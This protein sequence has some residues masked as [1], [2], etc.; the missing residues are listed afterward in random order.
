[1]ITQKE[2]IEEEQAILDQVIDQL[3]KAMMKENKALTKSMLEHQKAKD[4]CLPETYGDLVKSL[5][6]EEAAK[7]NLRKALNIKNELYDSHIRLECR[8]GIPST[9]GARPEIVDLKV[10]LH[11]YYQG[12]DIIVISWVRPLCR[13]Y[14]LDNSSVEYEEIVKER[15]GVEHH[16]FYNLKLKRNVDIFFDKVREVTHLFPV[17]EEKYEEV[18]ADE[19]LK[20]LMSRRS[21]QEFRNIVFS[22]QKKQGE[23][24]QTPFRQNLI[25]QGCAGSGKSMIMLHRLPILLYDN[26]G[27]LKRNNIFIITPSVTYIQMARRMM[28]ELEI[29]DLQLGTLDQYYLHV[30]EK[31]KQD[32]KEYAK[33]K[34]LVKVNST[35]EKYIYSPKCVEDISFVIR[36]Y[37]AAGAIDHKPAFV[38]LG[39]VY[40]KSNATLPANIIRAEVVKIQ[41][42]LTANGKNLRNYFDSMV[43]LMYALKNLEMTLATRRV[44]VLRNL[45][46]DI[47][48]ER[49]I[50]AKAREDLG[51]INRSRHER[52]YNNRVKTINSALKMLEVH[53][54]AKESVEKDDKYFERLKSIATSIS[55]L[56]ALFKVDNKDIDLPSADLMYRAAVLRDVFV[57]DSLHYVQELHEVEDPYSQYADELVQAANALIPLI[58]VFSQVDDTVIKYDYY[59]KLEKRRK[60]LQMLGNHISEDVYDYILKSA[61]IE[62]DVKIKKNED[63][64]EQ[65]IREYPTF[66]FTLYLKLQILRMLQ[67]TPHSGAEALIAIDEAQTIAPEEL[68]LISAV[69]NNKT[70]FNLY[71]DVKQ[72]VEG[73][74]GLDSWDDIQDV[75]DFEIREMNEN[76][77]NVRQITQYC[78]KRFN[79][80]M[81]AINL[82]G[83]GVHECR[84]YAQFIEILFQLFRTPRNGG[85]SS[86]IIKNE[87]EVDFLKDVM[88]TLS[89][90]M[91][92]ITS[93]PSELLPD[94][95]NVLTIDQAKGLEFETAI[96]LSGRMTE[97]EKYIAYT[98][99]LNNLYLFD[100]E[101]TIPESPKKERKTKKVTQSDKKT[102]KPVRE[103]WKKDNKKKEPE[104]NIIPHKKL[105]NSSEDDKPRNMYIYVSKEGLTTSLIPVFVDKTAHNIYISPEE[106]DKN[107]DLFAK[108][109]IV[110]RELVG[111]KSEEVNI[112]QILKPIIKSQ[113]NLSSQESA[114]NPYTM[115]LYDRAA[116][117]KIDSLAFMSC[118]HVLTGKKGLIASY[119][120]VYVDDTSRRIYISSDVY[121]NNKDELS[122]GTIQ[123]REHPGAQ[124]IEVKIAAI[125]IE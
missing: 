17:D 53:Q 80:N 100:Q 62:K 67:G 44:T 84:D 102:A 59:K 106:F 50:L 61:G 116:E 66:T 43:N 72:H 74:K 122:K 113:E 117:G 19:F 42:V 38:L 65:E 92:D 16:T 27:N 90:K 39:L 64:E 24:I 103:K 93:K 56:T 82:D 121:R 98:R 57:S 32:T 12:K 14:L 40:K 104:Y 7:Y 47:S 8:D 37:M 86:I 120:K 2:L 88:G 3:D 48:E 123:L 49:A 51:K 29:S 108:G 5:N 97:N 45:N 9:D 79:M 89:E 23:I 115:V 95:W 20:E 75:A 15:Y 114:V 96:V 33:V 4:K 41:E 68:R 1:M 91:N 63:G 77:R 118:K 112:G 36:S 70:V 111:T 125:T 78:N 46:K 81:Y 26:P 10:G 6:D 22:I 58:N 110:L 76:Y 35:I 94:K 73:T 13:H 30:M 28:F 105:G 60:Y 119:E 52:M 31:Y 87:G 18:I 34:R 69:N 109:T 55:E 54:K 11:T 101:V 71:G 107:Q 83:E 124:L 21:E 25:V 85:I 99:A